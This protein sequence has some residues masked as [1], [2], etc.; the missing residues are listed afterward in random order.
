MPDVDAV[1]TFVTK[2]IKPLILKT[3]T[4]VMLYKVGDTI[5]CSDANSTAY[6]YPLADG[7]ILGLK[8]GP[9]IEVKLDGTVYDLATGKV[10][11]WC[12]KNTPVRNLLGSLK[13]K[14]TPVD[15]PVY[16]VRVEGS[17][18]FVKLVK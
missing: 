9:A 16:P 17:K 5:Y 15:L 7:N 12:P 13:D 18:V 10:I 6:S 11:S 2:P 14:S 3:G 8:S 1:Q 4:A